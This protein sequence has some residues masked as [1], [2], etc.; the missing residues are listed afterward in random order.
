MLRFI[1]KHSETSVEKLAQMSWPQQVDH[2]LLHLAG[3]SNRWCINKN[4]MSFMARFGK[5]C[6]EMDYQSRN[7]LAAVLFTVAMQRLSKGAVLHDVVNFSEQ[8]PNKFWIYSSA[9]DDYHIMTQDCLEFIYNGLPIA[10]QFEPTRDYALKIAWGLA[11]HLDENGNQYGFS[12]YCSYPHAEG[13]KLFAKAVEIIETNVSKEDIFSRYAQ[14]NQWQKH[15]SWLYAYIEK[16]KLWDCFFEK[17]NVSRSL[18]AWQQRRKIKQEMKE[19][20]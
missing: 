20:A 17:I 14:T 16:E 4:F 2:I 18:F 7:N 11:E 9:H 5:D 10:A 3:G 6:I 12:L 8:L 1:A 19:A 13:K 15:K